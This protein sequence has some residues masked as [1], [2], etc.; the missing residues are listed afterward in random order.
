MFG[1][2]KMTTALLDRFTPHCH[3]VETGNDSWR[4]RRSSAAA[5]RGQIQGRT[6]ANTKGEKGPSTLDLSTT[7]LP[8]Y[9]SKGGVNIE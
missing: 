5:T 7:E 8:G 4:F 3:I 2:A 1:D 9:S 6:K